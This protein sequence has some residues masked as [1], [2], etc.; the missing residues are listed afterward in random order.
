MAEIYRTARG[1]LKGASLLI[2]ILLTNTE[3]RILIRGFVPVHVELPIVPVRVRHVAVRIPGAASAL[4]HPLH[5]KHVFF[6][7]LPVL[8]GD[9]VESG[10]PVHFTL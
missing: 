2:R 4:H 1:S 5:R 6:L 8:A 3:V 9:Y 10:T 7:C